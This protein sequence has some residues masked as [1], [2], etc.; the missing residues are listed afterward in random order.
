VGDRR[1]KIYDRR[2]NLAVD[3]LLPLLEH[4]QNYI[5]RRHLV[6][7]AGRLITDNP[8][9][10]HTRRLVVG[11]ADMV[12]FTRT[13]R[14]L[15]AVELLE[16]VDQFHAVAADLVAIHHGRVVKT[17]GDEVLFITQL[18]SAA[19][20]IAL[21]LLEKVTEIE[22]LPELRIGMALGPVSTRFGDVYGEV[23]NIASRLTTH[24]KPGRILIDANLAQAL[25]DGPYSVR[26]RR[27]LNVRGYRHLQSWGLTART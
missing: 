19:A 16:L 8:D 5:W 7:A 25:D 13:T 26:G 1:L 2:D 27:T 24:A 11:F 4:M 14:E 10:S 22:S 17:V 23:V 15:P 6:T 20:E 12:A 3:Q 18:P 9:E 21:G